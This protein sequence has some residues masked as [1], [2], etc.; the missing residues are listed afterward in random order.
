[1]VWPVDT[2]ESARRARTYPVA[3]VATRED[4]QM[5]EAKVTVP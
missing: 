3:G 2:G 4:A 1:V 5:S